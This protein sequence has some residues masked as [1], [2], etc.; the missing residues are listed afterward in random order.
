MAQQML[1]TYNYYNRYGVLLRC[2]SC[3]S[4]CFIGK[5]K[6][7]L[8]KNIRPPRVVPSLIFKTDSSKQRARNKQREHSLTLS[9]I[10]FGSFCLWKIWLWSSVKALQPRRT[11]IPTP[12]RCQN[13]TGRAVNRG[14]TLLFLDGSRCQA[15]PSDEEWR[16]ANGLH[17]KRP[18]SR[19]RCHAGQQLWKWTTEQRRGGLTFVLRRSAAMW[20][21][22]GSQIVFHLTEQTP[23]RKTGSVFLEWSSLTPDTRAA[24]CSLAEAPLAVCFRPGKPALAAGYRADVSEYVWQEIQLL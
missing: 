6:T 14:Q 12:R 11:R 5:Q 3:A 8:K 1:T 19:Y 2:C 9:P 15:A 10:C 16:R 20:V 17:R 13:S 4:S 18:L 22:L 23:Q 21:A 7:D 24:S